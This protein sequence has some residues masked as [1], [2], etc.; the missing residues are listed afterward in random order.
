MKRIAIVSDA[1]SNIPATT[2]VF[3]HIEKTVSII[4]IPSEI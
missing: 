3:K 4:F 2:A 1:H